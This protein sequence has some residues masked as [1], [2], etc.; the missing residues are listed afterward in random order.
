M[1]LSKILSIS[2]KPGLYKM[3]GQTKNGAIVESLADKKRFP[4][5]A[6]D[7]ISSLEEISIFTTDEDL[8]LKDVLKAM[9]DKLNGEKAPDHKSDPKK[10][11]EF[12]ENVIPNYD[13]ERVYNSDIKKIVN[14]YNLLH[15][16]NMLDFTE[17]ED[18]ENETLKE[19]E[20]KQEEKNP[21]NEEENT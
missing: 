11:K 7:S 15:E 13:Q 16:Y 18:K 5:F 9:H 6:T 2:G 14:W 17:E 12:F 19:E 21:E 10:L 1:D 4:A 20:K 8:A 3:I